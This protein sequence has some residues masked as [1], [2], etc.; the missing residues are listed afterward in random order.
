MKNKKGDWLCNFSKFHALAIIRFCAFVHRAQWCSLRQ[1]NC[2]SDESYFHAYLLSGL[3]SKDHLRWEGWLDVSRERVY[4]ETEAVLLG[5]TDSSGYEAWRLLWFGRSW[6]WTRV[7]TG[8]DCPLKN[9]QA[10]ISIQ[11]FPTDHQLPECVHVMWTENSNVKS[12]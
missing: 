7:L 6:F 11:G 2:Y 12:I 9:K 10:I 3:L 1:H 8:A 5:E 4:D